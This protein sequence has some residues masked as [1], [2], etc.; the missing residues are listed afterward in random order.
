VAPIDLTAMAAAA[1]AATEEKVVDH[2]ARRFLRVPLEPKSR[3][4]MTD[5]LHRQ[6]ADAGVSLADRNE[7]VEAALR[8]L[9]YLVL[10]TPEYQLG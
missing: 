9:L 8:E 3:A 2:F 7:K 4:A 1:G 6:L 5:F 10:S